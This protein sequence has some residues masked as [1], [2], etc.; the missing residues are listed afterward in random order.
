MHLYTNEAY[1]QVG[2][3]VLSGDMDLWLQLKVEGVLVEGG[4]L[5]GDWMNGV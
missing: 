1:W 5:D 4:H 2:T 3:L